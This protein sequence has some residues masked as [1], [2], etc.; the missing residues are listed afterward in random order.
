[1]DSFAA[2]VY[3]YMRRPKSAILSHAI[4]LAMNYRLFVHNGVSYKFNNSIGLSCIQ[5][6]YAAKLSPLN[7]V[8]SQVRSTLTETSQG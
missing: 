8:S 3:V 2:D 5:S 1:M 7:D 4:S 6:N